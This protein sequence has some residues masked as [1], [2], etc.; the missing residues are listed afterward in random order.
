ARDGD[1]P[2]RADS[3]RQGQGRREAGNGS[4]LPAACPCPRAGNGAGAPPRGGPL[5]SPGRDP[6]AGAVATK[7]T[8]AS[9]PR[10][11]RQG[12]SAQARA[13]D[14]G[15]RGDHPAASAVVPKGREAAP[16]TVFGPV[17]SAGV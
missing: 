6:S 2:S 1:C 14:D 7:D 3:R 17:P 13:R 12:G 4:R 9:D 11:S 10:T 16:L 15:G 5:P 8:Q